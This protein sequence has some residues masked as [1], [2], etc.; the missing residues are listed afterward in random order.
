[1]TGRAGWTLWTH[2]SPKESLIGIALATAFAGDL[3]GCPA[4]RQDRLGFPKRVGRP[5]HPPPARPIMVQTRVTFSSPGKLT[6]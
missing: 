5:G 3:P 1:M 6:P 2:E 4:L